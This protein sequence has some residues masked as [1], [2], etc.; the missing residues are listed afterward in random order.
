MRKS[1]GDAEFA[2]EQELPAKSI[3]RKT[4]A[5]SIKSASLDLV[6]VSSAAVVDGSVYETLLEKEESDSEKK[7]VAGPRSS[8]SVAHDQKLRQKRQS[9]ANSVLSFEVT[10]INQRGRRQKRILRLTMVGIENVRSAVELTSSIFEYS[11]VQKIVLNSMSQF[12]L[13]YNSGKVKK[14]MRFL[15]LLLHFLCAASVCLF[16]S[17]RNS[18]HLRDYKSC[19]RCSSSRKICGQV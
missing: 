18:H 16:V 13:H 19:K 10:K 8:L 6:D 2:S 14:H 11:S 12:S 9:V 15:L 3:V 4:I 5:S 7:E 1:L 17:C